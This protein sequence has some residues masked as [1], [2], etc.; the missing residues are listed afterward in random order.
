MTTKRVLVI[1]D[2]EAV[3]EVIQG[4][5]EDVGGWETLLASSGSEGFRLAINQ[6]P[7]AILLDVS[8][9]EMDGVETFR[10][11][12]ENHITKSIPIILLTAK[13]QPADRMRFAKLGIA[14]VIA[15]PFNPMTLVDLVAE[16]LD[17]ELNDEEFF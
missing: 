3:Q 2:E 15:K 14:G 6:L 7:D 4:C 16:I 5:L 10:R 13:V 17:W 11:L 9:P 12:Q 8:M 1:D